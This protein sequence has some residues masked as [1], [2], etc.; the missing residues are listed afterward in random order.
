MHTAFH[1]CEEFTM[2]EIHGGNA[3]FID[4]SFEKLDGN[5]FSTNGDVR[6]VQCTFDKDARASL[7]ENEEL[8]GLI[9]EYSK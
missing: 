4:C 2:F 6:L 3:D 1:D 7:D 5:L 9:R 8:G